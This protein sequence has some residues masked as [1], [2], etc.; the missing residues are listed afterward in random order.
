MD[1]DLI[2]EKVSS[3]AVYD[4]CLLHVRKDT[5]K[6]PNGNLATREWIK[7]PGAAAVLP[8]TEDGKLI[9]VRQYRY[10]I[11]QITLEIPAGKLDS[12]QEDPLECAKRELSEETG[13]EAAEYV[14]MTKL[15]T[16]VGFSNE[17]IYIYAAKGLTAGKQHPDA[18]EFINA[19]LLTEDEAVA[20][21][22]AGEIIDA[23]TITAVLLYRELKNNS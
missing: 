4:G 16:T 17:R 1:E 20:K 21:I 22:R 19:C 6:L 11:Q 5:A 9:F 8:V 14:F 7:H 13:Y 3:E 15:A 10:P 18:D 2:E 12:A 23:K